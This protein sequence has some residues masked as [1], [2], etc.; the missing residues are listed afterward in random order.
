MQG[1]LSGKRVLIVEDEGVIAL[2]LRKCLA[3]LGCIVTDI[4]R[5]GESGVE[6]VLRERPDLVIVDNGLPGISGIEA[7]KRILASYDVCVV[8]ISGGTAEDDEMRAADVGICAY[9]IKPLASFI[10]VEKLEQ[11]FYTYRLGK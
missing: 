10:L 1:I 7:A 9:L 2:Q 6:A 3:R 4:A 8:M 5:D 11:A